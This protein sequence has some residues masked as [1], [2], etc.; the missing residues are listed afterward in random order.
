MP[1]ETDKPLE[2]V[3]LRIEMELVPDWSNLV[4]RICRHHGEDVAAAIEGEE[5]VIKCSIDPENK[6]GMMRDL[7]N[8]WHKFAEQRR[9]AGEWTRR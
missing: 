7:E 4:E 5:Y 6:P 9:Q 8:F 2:I 3:A 1:D